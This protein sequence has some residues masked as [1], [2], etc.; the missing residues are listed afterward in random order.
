M[1]CFSTSQLGSVNACS[2][3]SNAFI[4]NLNDLIIKSFSPQIVYLISTSFQPL[5]SKLFKFNVLAVLFAST[6]GLFSLLM[7]PVCVCDG[8]GFGGLNAFINIIIIVAAF[9]WQKK[10]TEK[11]LK[12]VIIIIG[13]VFGIS[14]SIATGQSSVFTILITYPVMLIVCF[15]QDM[16]KIENIMKYTMQGLGIV[17]S[18]VYAG[19]S[20]K[21]TRD[22][23]LYGFITVQTAVISSAID[24]IA[25]IQ[26]GKEEIKK[27]MQYALVAINWAGVIAWGGAI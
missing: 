17:L 10:Y 1:T 11:D 18:A 15:V 20:G 16:K 12:L 5:I 27:G 9:N 22:N 3:S 21:E 24:V 23:R 8:N 7:N 2:R 13:C 19:I 26:A 6:F 4:L 25:N 14:I